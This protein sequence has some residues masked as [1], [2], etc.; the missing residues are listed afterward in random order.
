MGVGD[1][2]VQGK[3][4]IRDNGSPAER[5]NLVLLSDGYKSAEM[6]KYATDANNFVQTL[7]D[8]AP[9]NER[10]DECGQL[11]SHAINVY[12]VDVTS[13]DSGADDPVACGGTGATAATY[14][15]SSFCNN[16][17]RRLLLA[18]VTTAINVATAQVP[19]WHMIMVL[20]NS[21]T[22]GGG[23]GTIATFSMAPQAS[24]IGIHEMGH[25][26]FGLA[27]EYEYYLGCDIDTDRDHYIGGEP[28]QYNITK[29][30]DR[31]IIK[32]KTFIAPS[33][34]MPTTS[35][36]N[37]AV[38]DPQPNPFS[39]STV[40]AFEGSGYYH[41]GLYRPQFDC[42]MRALDH[43]FCAA[44]RQQIINKLKPFLPPEDLFVQLLCLRRSIVQDLLRVLGRID[45][46]TDPSPVDLMRLA[47]VIQPA[48]TVD[49]A[50]AD[51]LSDLLSRIETME[52]GELR[53]TLTRTKAA[54]A[55]LEAAARMIEKQ[56][57]SLG[58]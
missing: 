32:W 17:A 42:K 19:Q 16:G 28:A 20:V 23:G 47:R 2:T 21:T 5:W 13:T 37:C 22:Y 6:A 36:A 56:I 52:P 1:G 41:C 50:L 11:L 49:R 12:R 3:T 43:P 29:V 4:K 15:D 9:F 48:R 10:Q 45:W 58:Q 46:V 51:D 14:F 44:C 38:C 57:S 31:N 25:T 30:T 55:R 18:N 40:G 33:T 35:N 54:I 39:A 24:Q 7:F 26:G 27:D 34:P 53:T 8:T